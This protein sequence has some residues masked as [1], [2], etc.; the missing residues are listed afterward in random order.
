[1]DNELKRYLDE[2]FNA[3]AKKDDL[4]KQSKNLKAYVN[5]QTEKLASIIAT[6]IAEP[7]EKNFS[8]LKDFK[9][10]QEDVLTLKT[11]MQKIKSVLQ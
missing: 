1:M 6:T 2:Q 3:V 7:M 8:E 10:V 4:E 9:S 5:E 11:E